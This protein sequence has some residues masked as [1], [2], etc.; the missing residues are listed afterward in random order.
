MAN[1]AFVIFSIFI[2]SLLFY[3]SL[4][5]KGRYSLSASPYLVDVEYDPY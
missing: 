2:T 1:T 4:L 3:I 5:S